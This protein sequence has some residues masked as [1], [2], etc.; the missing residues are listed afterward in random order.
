MFQLMLQRNGCV[1]RTSIIS[2][3]R[4]FTSGA[5]R[6]NDILPSSP[7]MKTQAWTSGPSDDMDITKK[8]MGMA[9]KVQE[10]SLPPIIVEKLLLSLFGNSTT[11][12][13]FD[14]SMTK[15]VMEEN[16]ERKNR[17]PQAKYKG[18]KNDVFKKAGIDPRDLYLMPEILSKFLSP[19]GQI[20]PRE[21]TGCTDQNQKKLGIA[22]KRARVAG[23]L[24]YTG[25]HG[26]FMP[27]RLM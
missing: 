20:L 8:V 17:N 15:K 16:L 24:S 11:Y 6:C 12:N 26:R 18:G 7:K 21:V 2:S 22:I 13:P 10:K 1:A 9:R 27:K 19:T 25:R 4:S 23:L 14:F 3:V 5:V